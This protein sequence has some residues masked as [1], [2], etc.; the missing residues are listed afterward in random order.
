M[1]TVP[2]ISA[3]NEFCSIFSSE[4]ITECGCPVP[5]GTCTICSD[6]RSDFDPDLEF[7]GTSGAD[8]AAFALFFGEDES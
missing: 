8:L 5:E 1:L 4:S 7:E 3:D 2:F 6:G